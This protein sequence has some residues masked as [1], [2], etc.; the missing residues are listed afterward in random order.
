MPLVF[1]SVLAAALARELES[2]WSGRR[3]EG[4]RFETEPRRVRLE[5]GRETWVWLL[6]P[7]EGVLARLPRAGGDEPSGRGRRRSGRDRGVLDGPRRIVAV[8][9]PADT[10]EVVLGLEGPGGVDERLVFDLVANRWNAIHVADG[11]VAAVL[12]PNLGRSPPRPGAEWK[13]SSSGRRWATAPPS[14]D[15][16]TATM[17]ELTSGGAAAR[18]QIAWLSGTNEAAILGGG[19][20]DAAAGEAALHESRGRYLRLRDAA[21]RDPPAGW[22]IPADADA[23]EGEPQTRPYAWSLERADSARAGSV[24]DALRAWG[25]GS[26]RVAAAL[27]AAAESPEATRLR[28][29]LEARRERAQ[30]KIR[31]LEA[32]VDTARDPDELRQL[33]H[34]L[35][36]RKRDVPSGSEQARLEGFD[37]GVVVVPLDP[38]L[39]AVGNAEAFYDQAKRLERAAEALPGRMAAARRRVAKLDEALARLES[40]GPDDEAWRLAGGR[41]RVLGDGSGVARGGR[42]GR[43]GRGEATEQLPYRVFRTSSGLEIRAGRSAK[44]NDDL[45]FRHS[46]PDDIWMHVREAPGSHVVLRWGRRDQNPSEADIAEAAQV[47]AV[48]SRARGSTIVPVAWTRRKY[49]RKP[50][51]AAPGTVVPERTRT[52]FVEPDVRRVEAMAKEGDA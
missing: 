5:I 8:E 16:W 46:A 37:G 11:H 13:P 27:K 18:R 45:T 41:R 47:A 7:R 20:A 40:T 34:L 31:A 4:A 35:L 52:V 24:L 2:G 19:P 10:R 43:G 25:E 15:E 38:G 9:S 28:E 32:Q 12:V 39:D 17:R 22:L 14:A 51:K 50:R 1:D 30:K 23:G 36:A 33:G 6:H 48:L 26:E 49:V 21:L 42:A 3:L 29:A 44:A